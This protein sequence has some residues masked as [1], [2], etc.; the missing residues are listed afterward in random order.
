MKKAK[1]YFHISIF[2]LFLF[3]ACSEN[4]DTTEPEGSMIKIGALFSL[5][6][7][8]PVQGESV[9]AS[10]E[11]AV[12]DI[13]QYFSDENSGNNVELEISD[14]QNN[15]DTFIDR[16]QEMIDNNIKIIITSSTSAHLEII[17]SIADVSDVILIDQG[18]TSP[19]LSV[20]DNIFRFVPDDVELAKVTADVLTDDGIEYLFI[21]YRRDIWGIDLSGNTEIYFEQK[22]GSVLDKI[23]YEAR[24]VG[25]DFDSKLQELDTAVGQAISQYGA[26]KV[27]VSFICFEEG[28]D[29]FEKASS[30]ANLPSVK[31]YGS[32]GITQNTDLLLNESAA[33]FAID[34]GFL[35]PSFGIYDNAEL[36][37]VKAKVEQKTGQP[38][39]VFGLVAY[40]ALWVAGLTLAENQDADLSTLKSALKVKAAA[41]TGITGSIVLNEYENRTGTPYDF[42]GIAFENGSYIW[43]KLISSESVYM[44]TI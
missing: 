31:W 14:I 16:L 6:G 39:Y 15:V 4:S 17:K 7:G 19:T 27:A 18:S 11:T 32:D 41:Y 33:Q 8:G 40:D 20:S 43:E 9:K 5:S 25:D 2:I 38:A 35:S 44:V 24:V 28:V 36:N 22:G 42:W 37:E 23:Y 1:K 21:F 3:C 26:E 13:N 34:V 10:L 12:E 29:L 30:Y